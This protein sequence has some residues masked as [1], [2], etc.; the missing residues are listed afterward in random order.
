MNFVRR[1]FGGQVDVGEC[2]V[3]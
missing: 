2:A 3:L 1:F